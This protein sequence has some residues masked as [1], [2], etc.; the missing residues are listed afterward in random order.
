MRMSHI[1][2]PVM[3]RH[4]LQ[5]DGV[6]NRRK[7]AEALLADD[8]SQIEYYEQIVQK[9]VGRVLVSRGV[10]ERNKNEYRLKSWED[11]SRQQ[12]QEL[13]ELCNRKLSDFVANRDPWAHRRKSEG[14]ISGTLHYEVLKRAK[15]R[16]ELCGISGEEKA[17]EVDHI[18]PRRRGGTDDLHNLQALC[19]SHN[20]MK[21]D[22]DDTRF[23]GTLELYAHR[24]DGCVFCSILPTR[25]V[26]ENRLAVAIYDKHP[27]TQLHTLLIPKRH[28][29]GYFEL[30]QPER[31]ALEQLAQQSRSSILSQDKSVTGFNIG[32]N[33]GLDAGQS[34]L[35]CHLHLIPRRSGD[36]AF[37]R[38]GVRGVIPDRQ[39]Y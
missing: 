9:M 24:V 3:L 4:L 8:Q 34:I 13:I 15:F 21:R 38:G 14:Y 22:R 23:T 36:A 33:D 17:L 19:Y 12:V 25:I 5:H 18:L 30:F 11:L 16:C 1:Y 39:N 6:G 10:V 27:V 26:A 37:P 2:Q 32:A 29:A 7:I 28:V 35:H 31:N 20:A